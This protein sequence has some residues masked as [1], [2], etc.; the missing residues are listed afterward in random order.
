V[1]T[2]LSKKEAGIINKRRK[3]DV[4]PVFGF[5]KVNLSFNR[6]SVGGKSR[7]ENEIGFALIAVNLR[8]YTATLQINDEESL[9]YKV[10]SGL[11]QHFLLNQS[12]FS[13]FGPVLSRPLIV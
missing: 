11:I 8:K 9:I 6:F 13:Y 12:T 2:K 3:I 5:S 7:V 4:E 10:N 1:R